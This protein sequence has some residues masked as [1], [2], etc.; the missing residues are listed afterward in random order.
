[1]ASWR[2]RPA[3]KSFLNCAETAI[4]VSLAYD[5]LYDKLLEQERAAIEHALFRHILEPALAAYKDPGLLWP[6]RR[7]NCALCWPS[8]VLVPAHA[9][10][11]P[12]R[13]IAVQLV[14]KSLAAA[15]NIFEAFGPDG[16]WP[17]G[18]SYWSLAV[19]YA[20]LMV[21][22]LESTLGDSFGLA[23][24]PGFAQTGD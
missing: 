4:A 18:L 13:D 22:A 17:E 5:W 21:A 8:G 7:D 11:G 12:Y 16:V 10:L 20:S 2:R 15:R 3:I 1:T 23:D 24:R 9:V 6:K 14:A 19:R